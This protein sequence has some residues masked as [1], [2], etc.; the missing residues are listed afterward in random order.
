MKGEGFVGESMF[1]MPFD[2]LMEISDWAS[3]S[4]RW[5]CMHHIILGRTE[6]TFVPKATAT[7]AEAA[8][9]MQRF[10]ENLGK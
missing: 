7:R 5:C 4:V 8:A 2:D 1:L 6:T 9:M 3:E 10:C